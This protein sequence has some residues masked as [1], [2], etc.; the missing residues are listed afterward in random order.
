MD[1]APVASLA[2]NVAFSSFQSCQNFEKNFQNPRRSEGL[3]RYAGKSLV[4]CSAGDWRALCFFLV[5]SPTSNAL[6]TRRHHSSRFAFGTIPSNSSDTSGGFT[7]FFA[8]I[9]ISEFEKVA[10]YCCVFFL[11]TA[12]NSIITTHPTITHRDEKKRID[13]Q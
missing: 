4:F 1:G 10:H 11:V 2:R 13:L 8:S 9:E 3:R 5:Q 12:N 6:P 7:E